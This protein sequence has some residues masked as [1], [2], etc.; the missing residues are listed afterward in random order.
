MIIHYLKTIFLLFLVTFSLNVLGQFSQSAIPE[1]VIEPSTKPIIPDL[2]DI[3]DGYYF[4]SS[5]YQVNLNNSTRFYKNIKVIFDNAGTESAGNINIHYNP[6]YQKVVFHELYVIRNGERIN[7]LDL[8]KIKQL[9]VEEDLTRSIYN[10]SKSAYFIIEDLRNGDRIVTSYSIIGFNNVFQN[11]FFDTYNLQGYE[12]SGQ[13][14]VAY[15]VPK[16]RKLTFREYNNAEKGKKIEKGNDVI[17]VWDIAGEE[18]YQYGVN[19]PYWYIGSKYISCSEFAN[20]KELS[21][22]ITQI[23]PILP[24]NSS[25]SLAK[26]VDNTWNNSKGN[27]YI[28][29]Q[30]ITDFVQNEIRYM[31]VEVGEYSHKANS[32]EKVFTQRYGD[33]KDKSVLL[34]SILK[35]KNIPTNLVLANSYL[36]F[37][38]SK[39]LP[40]PSHFN[41]MIV[42]VDIDGR[43]QL[44]DPT[45]TNQG[46]DIKERYIPYYG[47]LLIT[48][49]YNSLNTQ[50]KE[51]NRRVKIEEVYT[52]AQ[53]YKATLDVKTVYEGGSAD[54][55]RSYFKSTAKNQVHKNYLEYYVRLHPKT[56]KK[57]NLRY[58]DDKVNNIFTVVESY[59]IPE[60]GSLDN[61]TNKRILPIYGSNFSNYIPTLEDTHSGPV[62]LDYPINFEYTIKVINANGVPLN[63]IG[64]NYFKDRPAYSY[65]KYIS[66]VNDTLKVSY[67]FAIHEP[68]INE[69]DVKFFKE[70]FANRDDMLYN[71]YFLSEEGTLLNDNNFGS[72][73]I[74]SFLLMLSTAIA[75]VYVIYKYYNRT[76]PRYF[77][78]KS[79][80]R[81]EENMSGWTILMGIGI[82]G[83]AF[84]L[85]IEIFQDPTLFNDYVWVS[86]KFLGVNAI[87]YCLLIAFELLGNT[88]VIISFIYC[89]YLYFKKRDIFPQ[90]LLITFIS[91]ILFVLFDSVLAT[92]ILPDQ[93]TF[94]S[95]LSEM[96]RMILFAVI[97][98][99][100]IL[101]SENIRNVFSKPYNNAIEVLNDDVESNLENKE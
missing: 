64:D 4:E 25:S 36:E 31:G 28:F 100:Y 101:N 37:E 56:T 76:E 86:Y 79:Y 18:K 69:S 45:I 35:Y 73:S 8:S 1:W 20:W 53:G 61:I 21:Q 24:I 80:E 95:V 3:N 5:Q 85:L 62:A 99:A 96:F 26:F 48:N 50:I 13:I 41:H 89:I 32:P 51:A 27:K 78:N 58:E 17:Y 82:I 30:H 38:L 15:I 66:T 33:C 81:N 77:Y 6:E 87:L 39:R 2:E 46:G 42:E 19:T 84:R 60:V 70:D 11:K 67:Q 22:W 12:P 54:E 92:Y 55:M 57:E 90:T 29:L 10:G 63:I 71:A 72:P 43:R 44:I 14:L 93:F 91:N 52:L 88:I 94:T 74:I 16:S 47:D 23:N 98:G 59:N 40:I 7:K 9:S 97:W 65:G 34:A 83:S 68:F 75:Y 49:S